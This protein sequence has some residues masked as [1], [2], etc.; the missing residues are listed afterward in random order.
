MMTAMMRVRFC[1][2]FLVLGVLGVSIGAVA[3]EDG[4]TGREE[5]SLVRQVPTASS[6]VLLSYAPV[7]KEVAP[8]V[9]NIYTARKVAARQSVF[10]DSF[11]RRFMGDNFSFGPRANECSDLWGR[12]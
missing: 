12:A 11:F 2:S 4:D 10:S 9:V 5:T 3:Q 6:E 8:A 1:L 7:V